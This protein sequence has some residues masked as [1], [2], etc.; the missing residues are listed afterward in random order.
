MTTKTAV[1]SQRHPGAVKDVAEGDEVHL[2]GIDGL[3]Q[4]NQ[5]LY[6]QI[7]EQGAAQHLDH[8]EHDPARTAHEHAEVPAAAVFFAVSG[9]MKRR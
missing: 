6:R 9:G 2:V 3:V 7:G 5:C 4:R 1:A 8:A